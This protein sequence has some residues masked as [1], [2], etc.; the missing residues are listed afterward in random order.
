MKHRMSQKLRVMF[1][2]TLRV[3][4]VPLLMEFGCGAGFKAQAVLNFAETYVGID[5]SSF[6]IALA[7]YR[8]SRWGQAHFFHTVYDRKFI[9]Q[10]ADRVD[11]I[12]GANFFYHQPLERLEPMIGLAANLLREGGWLLIDLLPEKGVANRPSAAPDDWTPGEAWTGFSVQ[13]EQIENILR[14]AQLKTERCIIT[15][16]DKPEWETKQLCSVLCRKIG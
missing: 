9:L 1:C 16:M 7:R 2:L 5:I 3:L 11:G 8:F 10:L 15:T 14:D 6:S 4:R 12:F 13:Y